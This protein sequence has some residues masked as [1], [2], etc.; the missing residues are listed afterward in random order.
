MREQASRGSRQI[1][2]FLARED[3]PAAP[4]TVTGNLVSLA[5]VLRAVAEE[6]SDLA[7]TVNVDLA[8][9]IR[10][11]G[12]TGHALASGVRT[13]LHNVRRHARAGA[14]TVHADRLADGCWEV[15][16]QDDGVGFDPDAVSGFGLRVQ[17]GSA[18]HEAGMGVVVD[19]APGEGTKVTITG[20]PAGALASWDR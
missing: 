19:S 11:S 9:G 8:A 10:V 3:V 6:F 17:A 13:L 18:L 15:T 2:A 4:G 5:G 16:V 7:L 1:R 12:A 20:E 14:V